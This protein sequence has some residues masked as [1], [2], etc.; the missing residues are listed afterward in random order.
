M[1]WACGISIIF[2]ISS[3]SACSSQES[4]PPEEPSF[5][6][7]DAAE[8]A[9][10]LLED[11]TETVTS[12]ANNDGEIIHPEDMKPWTLKAMVMTAKKPPEEELI[13]CRNEIF[14]ITQETFNESGLL[15]AKEKIFA[16]VNQNRIRYHWCFYFSMMVVDSKLKSDA[17]GKSIK[18]RLSGF[19]KEM[20]ALWI[21]ASTLD[22]AFQQERYFPYLRQRYIEISEMYFARRLNPIQD[23]LG[24]KA[25][26]KAERPASEFE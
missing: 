21:L 8:E 17:M 18:E 24:S 1:A 10:P 9:D 23:P 3:L 2:V 11:I 13:R 22:Q 15:V 4:P 25:K 14:A 6:D 7:L 16:D 5:E 20:K 19:H 26:P 12:G